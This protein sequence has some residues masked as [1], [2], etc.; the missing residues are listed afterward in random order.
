MLTFFSYLCTLWECSASAL[1]LAAATGRGGRK[2][3]AAQGIPLPN[4]GAAGDSRILQKRT[5]ATLA[6][7]WGKG[8]KAV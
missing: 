8:E 1:P 3:R 5:T 6:T 7:Q 4:I 2:V